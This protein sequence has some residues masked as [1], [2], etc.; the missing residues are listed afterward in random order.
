M[1]GSRSKRQGVNCEGDF[2]H[3]SAVPDSC[4]LCG[5]GYFLRPRILAL[6]ERCEAA[7]RETPR[8]AKLN[9]WTKACEVTL[10]KNHNEGSHMNRGI[11]KAQRWTL[12]FPLTLACL[13]ALP[14]LV[15]EKK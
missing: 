1:R 10:F 5:I 11:R 4:K 2:H 15:A 3:R 14:R 12:Y 13:F 8:L 9:R 7:R 6:A